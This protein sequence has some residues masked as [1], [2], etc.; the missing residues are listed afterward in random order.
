MSEGAFSRNFLW[1]TPEV[2][3]LI[4]RTRLLVVGCGGNGALFVIDAAHLGFQR[5]V[6][7]DA[8]CLEESNLNRFVIAT[9]AQL[10]EPK[11]EILR[12][13]LLSRFPNTEIQTVVARFPNQRVF[14]ELKTVDLAV[15]CLDDVFVRIE[16]DILCRKYKKTIID[17]GSGFVKRDEPH[18]GTTVVGA[19]GQVLVSRPNGP[20]LRCLGFD[21]SAT[22]N[23]YFLPGSAT[24]E[25]SSILLN[26]IVAAL[27]VECAIS[28]LSDPSTRFNRIAYDRGAMSITREY[29]SG[30][31]RCQICGK[32]SL[33]HLASVAQGEGFRK[34]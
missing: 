31:A 20:C 4:Q 9:R 3:A 11:V 15:A 25:P 2:R 12:G 1:L 14:D 32:E 34:A 22:S 29:R 13:Y 8:D 27:G 28:E 30:D 10:H 7:C 6:L 19:G 16:F 5:F 26:S 23:T 18:T 24:A 21:L 17:L 33:P